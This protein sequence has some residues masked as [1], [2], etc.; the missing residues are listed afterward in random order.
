MKVVPHDTFWTAWFHPV[1]P[2]VDVDFVLPVRWVDDALEE[3]DLELD[4]LCFAD[5][6]VHVRDREEFDR[7][8]AAW[9]MPGDIVAQAEGT[10]E[11]VRALVE[12]GAEPF[13]AVG[14]AWLARFL[15][16]AGPTRS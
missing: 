13:G 3:V 4:I 15:T 2:V 12:A 6:S 1:D 11:R 16:D 14:R 5:G 10:C 9:A 8:R 7:V